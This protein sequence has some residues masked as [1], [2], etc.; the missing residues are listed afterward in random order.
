ML[1]DMV[2]IIGQYFVCNLQCALS[3]HPLHDIT[4]V[5]VCCTCSIV[6]MSDWYSQISGRAVSAAYVH[7]LLL[8]MYYYYSCNVYLSIISIR[9][10]AAFDMLLLVYRPGTQDI[11]FGEVDR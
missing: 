1:A 7:V 6:Y 8:C 5:H 9:Y 3:P 10:A 4:G 2:A 11:V